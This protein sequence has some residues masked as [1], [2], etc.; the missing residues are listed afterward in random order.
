MGDRLPKGFHGQQCVH[1][2]S[3]LLMRWLSKATQPAMLQVANIMALA[4]LTGVHVNALYMIRL[5]SQNSSTTPNPCN[6]VFFSHSL[7]SALETLNFNRAGLDTVRYPKTDGIIPQHSFHS[8]SNTWSKL[9]D[10]Q[11][12]SKLCMLIMGANNEFYKDLCLDQSSSSFIS[13]LSVKLLVKAT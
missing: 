3:T 7:K 4:S 8:D 6:C 9:G 13:Y 1:A 2:R 5:D 11:T 10:I 12:Y